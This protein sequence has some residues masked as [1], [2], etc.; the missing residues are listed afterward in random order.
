M[1]ERCGD[2]YYHDGMECAWQGYKVALTIQKP[3]ELNDHTKN[4]FGL[5]CFQ[6][7][8]IAQILRLST[9]HVIPYKA[10]EE[11]AYV[12]HWMLNIYLLYGE[13]WKQVVQDHFDY[14]L[15]EAKK[16]ETPGEKPI[17]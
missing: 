16:K 15:A 5:M 6:A 13:N 10:E 14:Y 8:G 12:I 3:I 4:I 9:D 7:S 17:S 1:H 11:Q 2:S